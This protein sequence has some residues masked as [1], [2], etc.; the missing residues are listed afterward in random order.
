V[1]DADGDGDADVAAPN[2]SRVVVFYNAGNGTFGAPR[3]FDPQG[4]NEDN[5]AAADANGDGKTDLFVGNLGSSDVSI[6]LGDGAGNFT[7]SVRRSCGGGP[8]QMAVGDVDGD[9][10]VDALTANHGSNTLGVLRGNGLGGFLPGVATYPV[11]SSPA[12]VDVG[13]LDGDGWL[14]AAVSNF[15]SGNY[16]IYFNNGA[17]VF[18][19]PQTLPSTR[20][21]SCCTLVDFDRDGDLDI[22]ATDEIVDE[23]R[24]Y[25]HAGPTHGGSQPPS[26]A[27]ALRVNSWGSR[28]GFAGP[29]Q[30]VTPGGT[31]FF[32]TSGPA[33]AVW[34]IFLGAPLVNGIAFPPFGV[35][36]LD[37]TL[38]VL[39]VAA[40]LTDAFGEALLPVSIP[41]SL[42]P[43]Q[44]FALQGVVGITSLTLTN[45]EAVVTL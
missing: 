39:T 5:I 15:G 23:A 12:A 19:N 16:T 10:N 2:N 11:G 3:T 35:F 29:A 6:M 13:D 33:G 18:V 24:L 42:P 45:P 25:T 36:N 30:G 43:G 32:G 41:G 27:A 40:G 1:L 17:G 7:F 37:P 4:T 26:C 21:G 44:T 9:G 8:F 31:A 20:A 28:A 38:P 22:I 34:G 14:D